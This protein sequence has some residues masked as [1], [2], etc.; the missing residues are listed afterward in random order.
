MKLDVLMNL[1]CACVVRYCFDCDQNFCDKC[2][3]THGRIRPLAS[4]KMF[5][6]GSQT[7]T[8]ELVANYPLDRCEKHVDRSV[9]LYCNTC[10]KALCIACS[11]DVT[12]RTHDRDE[13]GQ[14]R[15]QL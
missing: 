2:S 10:R 11:V 1:N 12:H 13:V 9:E 14:A 7:V 4:H 8:E 5:E 3:Q 6:R 15:I